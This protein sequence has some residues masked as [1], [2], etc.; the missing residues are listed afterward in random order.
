MTLPAPDR[1]KPKK[2][3]QRLANRKLS[4]MLTMAFLEFRLSGFAKCQ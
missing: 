2:R 4:L 3:S 1:G